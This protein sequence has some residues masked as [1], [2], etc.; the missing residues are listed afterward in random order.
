MK[1]IRS[2]DL[3]IENDRVESER[4]FE[5]RPKASKRDEHQGAAQR[6]RALLKVKQHAAEVETKRKILE[7]ELHV[8]ITSYVQEPC[9]QLCATIL[10]T[11]PRELRDMIYDNLHAHDTIYVGPE[12][13]RKSVQPCETDRGAHYWDAEYVGQE[14]QRELVES[15]YRTTLFY[16]YDKANNAEVVT[17]F[18][19]TD[20]WALDVKPRS[21]ICRVRFDLDASGGKLH[22][23]SSLSTMARDFTQDCCHLKGLS[24]TLTRPLNNLGL[25]PNHV[26]FFIRVHTLGAFEL[27]CLDTDELERTVAVLVEDLEGLHF[28]GHRFVV[29]WPE[30]EDLEFRSRPGGYSSSEWMQRLQAG[31]EAK[32]QRRQ[33]T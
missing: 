13:M 33:S 19:D 17:Q 16:F 3:E 26:H 4:L 7:E 15:W 21:V 9:K 1:K 25:L 22:T 11:L 29:Q 10:E 20:R 24:K 8:M 27:G 2:L 30:L 28:A 6:K 5:R 23:S 32:L 12:Y 18:L 14:M 31:R